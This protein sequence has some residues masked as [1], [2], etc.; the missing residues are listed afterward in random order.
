MNEY[1]INDSEF[2]KSDIYKE[3]IKTNEGLGHLS[4]R[5]YA[6]SEALPIKGLKLGVSTNFDNNKIVLYDGYT[7][8]SGVIEDI[9]LPAPIYDENNLVSPLK[10]VY[11]LSASYEPSK[12][13]KEYLINMFDG[14]SV[15]QNIVVESM[16]MEGF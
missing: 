8:E 11:N 2:L 7:D 1:N 5:A 14:I 12:F 15:M 13:Y 4:V 10:I 16:D 3:F 9:L 6:A